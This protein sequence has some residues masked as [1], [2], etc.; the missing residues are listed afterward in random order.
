M[1]QTAVLIKWYKLTCILYAEKCVFLSSCKNKNWFKFSSSCNQIMLRSGGRI[2]F[3]R[4]TVL[5][6]LSSSTLPENKAKGK[7][8]GMQQN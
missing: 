7:L 1:G 2:L 4:T 5:V 3:L 6:S 8:T